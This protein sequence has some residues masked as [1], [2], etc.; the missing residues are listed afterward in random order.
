MEGRALLMFAVALEPVLELESGTGTLPQLVLFKWLLK[1][2]LGSMLRI[3]ENVTGVLVRSRLHLDSRRPEIQWRLVA[4][5]MSV[6]TTMK[7]AAE[8]TEWCA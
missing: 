8:S 4:G 2:A 5:E 3:V 1:P 7:N 6:L